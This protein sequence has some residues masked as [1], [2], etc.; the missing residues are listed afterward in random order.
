VDFDPLDGAPDER[1]RQVADQ[2]LHFGQLR[3]TRLSAI[4]F[5]LSATRVAADG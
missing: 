3:H 1:R 4:S 5:Q 2:R